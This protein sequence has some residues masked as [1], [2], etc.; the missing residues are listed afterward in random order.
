MART[1]IAEL[2]INWEKL[3]ANVRG[4]L[5]EVPHLSIH[6]GPLELVLAQARDLSIRLETRKGIK[7]QESQERRLLLKQGNALASRIRAALKA[8]YGLDNE[9]LVE[10]GASPLRGRSRYKTKKKTTTPQPPETAPV[11]VPPSNPETK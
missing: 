6:A 4:S 3:V 1:S 2:I 5:S 11:P 7:Q 10:Y 8:H 9:R